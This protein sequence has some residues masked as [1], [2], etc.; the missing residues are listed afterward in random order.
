MLNK[1]KYTNLKYLLKDK[2]Y[3]YDYFLIIFFKKYK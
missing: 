3:L 2:T 1:V